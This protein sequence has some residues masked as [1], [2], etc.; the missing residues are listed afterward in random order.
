MFLT[1]ADAHRRNFGGSQSLGASDRRFI[2]GGMVGSLCFPPAQHHS[3]GRHKNRVSTVDVMGS[4]ITW[5]QAAFEP[6]LPLTV[7]IN[8]ATKPSEATSGVARQA[9][10]PSKQH[11][12]DTFTQVQSALNRCRT[13]SLA[14]PETAIRLPADG[15]RMAKPDLSD[16]VL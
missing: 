5:W 13:G 12:S 3:N 15:L 6:R 8:I 2:F 16:E 14:T 11:A 1:L 9:G 10:R 4:P 7:S